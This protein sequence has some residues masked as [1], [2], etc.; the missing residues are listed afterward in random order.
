MMS[1]LL[2]TRVNEL[3]DTLM[4]EIR[5]LPSERAQL[6]FSY[7]L[8]SDAFILLKHVRATEADVLVAQPVLK[9]IHAEAPEGWM[10]YQLNAEG[11]WQP[12]TDMIFTAELA[13][14]MTVSRLVVGVEKTP[15]RFA[16]AG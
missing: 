14:V 12:H 13:D 4:A 15:I 7:K 10:I 9:V 1:T 11:H 6:D 5:P 3:L 16:L 2:Q 8:N